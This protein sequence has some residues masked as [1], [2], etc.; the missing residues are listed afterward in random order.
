MHKWWRRL[1]DLAV[2]ASF[3]GVA[4]VLLEMLT[5]KLP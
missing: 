5:S 3:F 1:Y 2:L 4:A